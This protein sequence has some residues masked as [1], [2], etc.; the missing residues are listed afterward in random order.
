[1]LLECFINL[2][3]L[4]LFTNM[5]KVIIIQGNKKT[6][7]I[8]KSSLNI[9]KCKEITDNIDSMLNKL[10]LEK[11]PNVSVVPKQIRIGPSDELLNQQCSICHDIY[12]CKE[13]KRSLVCN[14]T[15]HKK[16]IDKWLKQNINCPMCRTEII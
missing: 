16:C 13:Y 5:F 6:D 8:A 10:G 12:K 15:F 11:I 14:H 3:L 7:L 9:D 1:M 2:F 4:F